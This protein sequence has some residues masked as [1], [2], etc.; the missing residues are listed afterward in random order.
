[1]KTLL[2]GIIPVFILFFIGCESSPNAPKEVSTDQTEVNNSADV[3]G[4]TLSDQVNSVEEVTEELIEMAPEEKKAM[5]EKAVAN[6]RLMGFDPETSLPLLYKEMKNDYNMLRIIEKYGKAVVAGEGIAG[7]EDIRAQLNVRDENILPYLHNVLEAKD[8]DDN[9][10]IEKNYE[11]LESE[12]N[13]LG[14]TM[15]FAEGTYVGLG[16][17]PFMS[18]LIQLYG[19]E[20]L[21][22]FTEFEVAEAASQ[23]GEYPYLDMRP[24]IE[25]VL[26]G[27]KLAKLE[28][29]TYYKKVKERYEN[30][31]LSLTDIH[32]VYN[33]NNRQEESFLVDGISTE[34]YPHVTE[35][36][37]RTTFSQLRTSSKYSQLLQKI[38][39]N[40]SEIS[41]K[42]TQIYVIV[43]E[44]IETEEMARSRVVGYL[45]NGDDVPHSL[46]IRQGDGKD[47]FAIAYRFFENADKA[48]EALETI[49]Q[50][51][52]RAELVYCSV[53]GGQLYQIGPSKD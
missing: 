18:D 43:T 5:I 27:E 39:E 19:S 24:Y 7:E 2:H 51:M 11:Q 47:R 23:N 45:S 37:S 34:F 1:M 10:F 9:S 53:K 25:M 44:W 8:M 40:P 35:S 31:L 3:E 16:A 29:Q 28:D 41:N 26:A 38:L 46:R 13:K 4:K 33:P 52:P 6:K 12:L 30:A 17:H 15:I 20:G 50:K 14:L 36:K 21:A 22:L 32:K 42:P 49:R 48:S